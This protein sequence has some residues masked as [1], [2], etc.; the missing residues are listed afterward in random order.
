MVV[1]FL[2]S[3]LPE[4]PLDS[5]LVLHCASPEV[6]SMGLRVDSAL[7][8][9]RLVTLSTEVFLRELGVVSAG[10]QAQIDERLRRL[11][12]LEPEKTSSSAKSALELAGTWS[13]MPED[14]FEA[15]LNEIRR[16]RD[17]GPSHSP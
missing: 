2:T 4:T 14:E 13:D 12:R 16:R 6:Q 17:R 1:G 15:F 5:D 8:L 9:H 10:V 7:R 11:F 3:R